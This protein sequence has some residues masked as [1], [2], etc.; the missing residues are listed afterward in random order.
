MLRIEIPT[1]LLAVALTPDGDDVEPG[2]ALAA[3]LRSV[4][5]RIETTLNI[6]PGHDEWTTETYGAFGVVKNVPMRAIITICKDA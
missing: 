1:D 3:M 5:D 4:A 6:L 2:P